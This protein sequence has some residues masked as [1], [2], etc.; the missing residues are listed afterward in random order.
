M[1]QRTSFDFQ[2]HAYTL[3]VKFGQPGQ[4]DFAQRCMEFGYSLGLRDATDAVREANN[5]VAETK[6][7]ANLPR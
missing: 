7:K 2:L 5:K 6:A 3:T 1:K 4:V